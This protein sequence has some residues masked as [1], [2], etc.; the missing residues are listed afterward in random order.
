[1]RAL[2]LAA[3]LFAALLSGACFQMTTVLRVAADG[4]GTIAHR[5]VYST[6]ALAQLRQFAALS[7]RGGA[8]GTTF[9][10][11]S[12]QQARDMAAS[13]GPGVTF[14]SS[15]PIA[16][17]TGQGRE[18]IYA[19][20]DVSTLRIST[21]PTAPGGLPINAP[22]LSP[23]ATESITFSL[24]HEPNGNA[25]LHIFVPEPNFLDA[26]G[27]PAAQSQIGMV[28]TMLAGARMLLT[29]E[30]AGPLVGS[31]SPYVDGQRVTLLEVDLDEV[32]K[33]DTLLPR[34]Q[35]AK[36]EDEAKAIVQSARGL[37]INLQRDITIEFSPAK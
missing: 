35:A 9:D 19:F 20:T 32:L 29:A 17:A 27:S 13:I 8:N 22:G 23:G 33:D 2:R 31:S 6:Q 15:E 30:P 1:M 34:L 3:L 21:Q 10:P 28:K 11:L 26:L 5:M 25:V 16:S 7:G 12:E 37:K 4:S 14:V 18:T 36:T 24:T